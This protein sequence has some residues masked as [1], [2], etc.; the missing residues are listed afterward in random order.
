MSVWIFAIVFSVAVAFLLP[1]VVMVLK[2]QQ[3]MKEQELELA[4]LRTEHNDGE[5]A[6]AGIESSDNQL[7]V[8]T[9]QELKAILR[10]LL[11]EHRGLREEHRELRTRLEKLEESQAANAHEPSTAG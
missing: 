4:R 7:D 1:V 10:E 11:D 5:L 3:R 9:T 8:A 2:H 6:D